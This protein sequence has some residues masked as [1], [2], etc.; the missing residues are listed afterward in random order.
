[1]Q[2]CV[3]GIILSKL[4]K[5]NLSRKVTDLLLLLLLFIVVV[6]KITRLPMKNRLWENMW[7]TE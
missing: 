2:Y 7:P 6:D 3:L 1:M 5:M 4:N